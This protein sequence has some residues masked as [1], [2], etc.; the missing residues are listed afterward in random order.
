MNDI[1]LSAYISLIIQ[2]ITGVISLYGIFIP[3]PFK[4]RILREILILET[5]VQ[6]IEFIFYVWLV[7][8]FYK[9]NYDVTYVRYFDWFWTTPV[10]ILSTIYFFEY[11]TYE[12]TSIL[13]ITIKDFSYLSLIVICNFLMLLF[14]FLGEI[15]KIYKSISIIFGFIFLFATFYLIYDKYV[16]DKLL[17][18]LL[19]FS[20]L[21]IW[22][23]Y[24][25]AFLLP[26]SKKN[27]MYN[28]LDIFSKNIYSVFIFLKI[29]YTNIKEFHGLI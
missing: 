22:I 28:I 13:D 14:G 5:I 11:I 12:S 9:I 8:S 17:N 23:L 2:F 26:Y 18:K 29:Y 6:V 20:M 16:G 10:M 19:F 27:T 25:I 21:F 1:L 7:V 15:K 24:G 4:D 3:L